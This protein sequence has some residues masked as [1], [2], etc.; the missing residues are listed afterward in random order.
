MKER[1][2]EKRADKG[3]EWVGE[4]SRREMGRIGRRAV[5]QSKSE[6]DKGGEFSH[7]HKKN[8]L[9]HRHTQTHTHRDR[10]YS[11]LQLQ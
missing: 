6:R 9:K 4:G 7:A 3:G 11:H 8:S 5:C 1:E 10:T 2:E